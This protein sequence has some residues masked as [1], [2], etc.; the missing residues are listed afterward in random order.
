LLPDQFFLDMHYDEVITD[1]AGAMTTWNQAMQLVIP[2]SLICL[3]CYL[4]YLVIENKMNLFAEELNNLEL[5]HF[6]I[7]KSS[8]C[9]VPKLNI[10]NVPILAVASLQELIIVLMLSRNALSVKLL[11]ILF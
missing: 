9:E 10:P 2:Y 3:T 7:L 5:C 6:V 4:T 11:S 1:D 8:Y